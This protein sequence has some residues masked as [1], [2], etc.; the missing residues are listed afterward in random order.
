MLLAVFFLFLACVRSLLSFFFV[1]TCTFVFVSF[2]APALP[3]NV[4]AK[5]LEIT[6]VSFLHVSC[7]V[8]TF[9]VES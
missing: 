6:G 3:V 7:S 1:A 5:C 9:S 2:V 4:V 8:L